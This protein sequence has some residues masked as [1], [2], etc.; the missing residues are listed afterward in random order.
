MW[1][2]FPFVYYCC[3]SVTKSCLTLCDAMDCSMPG[4]PVLHCLPRFAQTHVHWVENAIQSSHPLLPP[5]P[6]A[7][8]LSQPQGLFQWI[9]SLHQVAKLQSIGASASVL[10]M[11]IQGWF[12]FRLTGLISLLSRELSRDFSSTTVWKH[13]IF[14]DQPSL[15][16]NSHIHMWLLEKPLTNLWLDRSLLAS[17]VST[18]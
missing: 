12:P 10:P 4:F 11:N 9:S 14:A 13:Q 17:D 7:L 8:N 16:S 6:P 3:F 5:S 18:F 2:I 15:W 1:Y